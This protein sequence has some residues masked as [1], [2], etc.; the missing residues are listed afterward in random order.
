MQQHPPDYQTNRKKWTTLFAVV[1]MTC[2]S[3]IDASIVN[4]AMPVMVRELSVSLSSIEWVVAAYLITICSTILIFGRLGDMIG[5]SRVFKFGTVLFTAGSLLC[6]LSGSFTM[7]VVCRVIQGVGASAYMANNQGI[8]TQIFPREER[9]KALGF[10]GASVALGTM[11]GPSFGGIITSYL[12]WNDIFFINVPFGI[13]AALLS[14]RLLPKGKNTTEKL[15]FPG[16][17]ALITGTTLL[18]GAII[19][20]QQ[21]GFSNGY[22]LAAI[23]IGA[24]LF[25]LFVVIESKQAQPLLALPIFKNRLFSLSLLC[26]FISFIC[27]QAANIIIPIYFEDTLKLSPAAAGFFM[28]LSPIIVAVLSPISGTVSDKIGSE[29]ITLFG[30][31]LMTVGFLLLATLGVATALVPIGLFVAIMSIGQGIFQPANNSL[32][33]SNVP[34]NELGIAGSVNALIRNLGLIGGMT[35]STTVLYG[36]MS[37]KLHRIVSDYVVGRDDVFVFGMKH[38]YLVL[39]VVCLVGAALTALR[40][41]AQ[42]RAAQR[43]RGAKNTAAGQ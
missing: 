17:A 22:V 24:A 42:R 19:R 4:V 27:I 28:M 41:F 3:C 23:C 10:L 1:L 6:G 21:I 38:V 25:V 40:F 5:K 8:I 14:F 29:L 31:A 26:G 37:L 11:L 12:R 30:L 2:L 9:G 16:A 39:A 13:I 35:L 34:R 15:D 36:F 20:G 33:M 32:V 18:F 7:L 43:A